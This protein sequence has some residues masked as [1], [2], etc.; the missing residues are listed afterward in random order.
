MKTLLGPTGALVAIALLASAC[1]GKAPASAP[2]GTTLP[3]LPPDVVALVTLIGSGSAVGTGSSLYG[4]DLTGGASTA[5]KTFAVGTFPDAVAVTPNGKTALVANYGAGSVTPINLVS[6]KVLP[7]IQ[8]GSGPAGVAV[9]P[10]GKMAYVTDAG[11]APIGTTITPIDLVT[12]KPLSPITVG[13]GPQGIA[14]SPDGS[15]AWVSLAGAVVVGQSGSVGST[16]V[17]VNLATKAVSAPVSVGN[18]PLAVALS[19]DGQTLWVANSYSGS[20]TPITT[21]TRVAGTPVAVNG[22]PDALVVS[23]DSHTVYVA[24]ERSSVAKGNNV[25]PISTSSLSPSAPIAV[26][27]APTGLAV[28]PDGSTLWVV[29]SGAGSLEP[30]DLAAAPVAAETEG[31]VAVVGGPYAI[32]LVTEQHSVAVRSL[33]AAPAKKKHT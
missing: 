29:C 6:G 30:I 19:N 26:Q 28:T 13:A 7:A 8:A 15:T 18:A 23:P 3:P 16:V 1:G 25:T 4:V 14:I 2:T 9:T 11:S 31:A 27:K 20:V 24:D 10:N 12:D 32:A 17:S 33:G 22:A 5:A 21:S